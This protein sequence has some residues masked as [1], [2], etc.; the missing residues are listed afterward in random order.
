MAVSSLLVPHC[1]LVVVVVGCLAGSLRLHCRSDAV[2]LDSDCPC[3]YD[4]EFQFTTQTQQQQPMA[5]CVASACQ[6][7]SVCASV[8]YHSEVVMKRSIVFEIDTAVLTSAL[9]NIP[10]MPEAPRLLTS[11]LRT[12]ALPADRL[13]ALDAQ[14]LASVGI[15]LVGS[16]PTPASR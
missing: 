11:L 10:H 7:A 3:A 16:T 4:F 2:E 9:D 1:E 13:C 14:R 15:V 5:L 12:L 6:C 8:R